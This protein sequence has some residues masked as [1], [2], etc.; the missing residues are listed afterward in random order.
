MGKLYINSELVDV[1]GKFDV[2]FNREFI[3]LQQLDSK[4]GDYTWTIKLPKTKRN[5]VIFGLSN[6]INTIDKFVRELH[7]PAKYETNGMSPL[8]GFFLLKQITKT[9]FEGIL[10]SNNISWAKLI[11]KKN[12]NELT[13]YDGTPWEFQFIGASA[14]TSPYSFAWHVENDTYNNSDVAFPLIPRGHFWHSANTQLNHFFNDS[15]SFSDIPPSVYELKILK[16]IFENIGWGVDGDVINN[17]E[18]QKVVVPFCGPE[19]YQWNTNYLYAASSTGKTIAYDF[20]RTNENYFTE[21]YSSPQNSLTGFVKLNPDDETDPNDRIR[22]I[23][24]TDLNNASVSLRQYHVSANGKLNI[25]LHFDFVGGLFGT[26][27][28]MNPSSPFRDPYKTRG[29]FFIYQYTSDAAEDDIFANVNDYLFNTNVAASVSDPRIIYFYDVFQSATFGTHTA[30]QP[31]DPT[32]TVTATNTT[33]TGFNLI[34]V[35]LYQLYLTGG[36]IDINLRDINVGP[37]E[38]LRMAWAG[39]GSTLTVPAY[40]TGYNILSLNEFSWKF[41]GDTG[42]TSNNVNIATNLGTISQL[43][44]VKDFITKYNLFISFEPDTHT[45]RLDSFDAFFLPNDFEYD[46][47]SKV[48]L[49]YGEPATKPINLPSNIFYEYTNDENDVLVKQDM[50]YGN[51]QTTDLNIYKSGEQHITSL[52]SSTRTRNYLFVDS[53][54]TVDLPCIMNEESANLTDLTS[55][56]WD[57]NCAPRILKLGNYWTN[58]TGTTMYVNIDGYPTKVLL[59]MFEDNG[60]TGD[61]LSL[62][63]DTENGLVERYYTRFVSSIADSHILMLDSRINTYDYSKMLPQVPIKCQT[64]HYYVGKIDAFNPDDGGLTKIELIRKFTS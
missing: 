32:M 2:N 3:D 22:P 25:D 34:G 49:N 11:E 14:S 53:A 42:Q 63:F 61:T 56:V 54:T 23:T 30:F 47:T 55:V 58:A 33:A 26:S 27:V 16:K 37:G 48:D 44:F 4:S 43:E 62:R 17:S 20:P 29:G 41:F 57:F 10:I 12:L 24:T 39:Y 18:H 1:D 31:Y 59:S 38:E 13:N 19:D 36:T 52:F 9:H 6:V 28:G 5:A 21:S 35:L 64:G 40:R 50:S 45:V 15:I 51:L 7:F 60:T 46:I 8:D